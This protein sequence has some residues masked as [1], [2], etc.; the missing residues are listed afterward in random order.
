MR[1]CGFE[2]EELPESRDPVDRGGL[3]PL[4]DGLTAREGAIWQS[5]IT[6]GF[7]GNAPAFINLALMSTGV[8]ETDQAAPTSEAILSVV[9]VLPG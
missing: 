1:Q 2:E 4:V 6:P 7:S 3:L 9:V 5:V 8:I